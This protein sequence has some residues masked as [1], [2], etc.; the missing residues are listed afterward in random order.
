MFTES[1]EGAAAQKNQATSWGCDFRG[2]HI[3]E[4]LSSCALLNKN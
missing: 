4:T 1:W 3:L 2:G